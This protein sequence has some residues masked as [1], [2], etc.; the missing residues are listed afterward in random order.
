MND[1]GLDNVEAARGLDGSSVGGE[2]G[3]GWGKA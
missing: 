2:V 3:R 1:T